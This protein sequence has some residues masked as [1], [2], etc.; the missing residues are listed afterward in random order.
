MSNGQT[1]IKNRVSV[2]R[3][4]II[5]LS[6]SAVVAFGILI[7]LNLST[8]NR[9][10]LGAK[11]WA[12]SNMNSLLS[13][14]LAGAVR[15]KKETPVIDSLEAFKQKDIDKVFLNA[16]V[17]LTDN[18]PW[19][20]FE[21]N[22]SSA[23]IWPQ[24]FIQQALENEGN[25]STSIGNIFTTSSPILNAKNERIGTLITSWNHQPIIQQITQDSI[26]AALVSL[27]LMTMMVAFIILFNRKLVIR[28]LR[29]ITIT[30]SELAEGNTALEVPEL[31][32]RDEIG[33]IASALEVLKNNAIIAEKLKQQKMDADTENQRQK[34]ILE[35]AEKDKRESEAR[36]QKKKL[37][38]AE[39]SAAHSK[40]LKA[41]ISTL[42]KA[43][44]AASNGNLEYP[45][46]CTQEEDD[47][48]SI[49]VALDGLFKQLRTSFHDIEKSATGVSQAATELS[50]IGKSITT[51][52]T[53][54]FELTESASARASNVSQSVQT[55]AT[56]T[57]E[58]TSTIKE[59]SVNASNAVRTVIEAVGLVES[60][61]SNINRLSDSSADI[62]SVIKDITS[63]AEQTNLLAL[64][65]T[66]EA[67]RAGDAGKGFA[68]VANEVK[69]LAKDTA[70]A[71]EEIE[72]RIE[73]IQTDTKTAVAAINQINDVVANI[74]NSQSSIAAAVE[75][76]KATSN[77]LH[78]TIASASSDNTAINSVF[79]D[80]SEQSRETKNTAISVNNAA[81]ELTSHARVLS[82]LLEHWRVPS[83]TSQ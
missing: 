59:I 66:I 15:W 55:A 20:E 73:S 71:T 54:N 19:V 68:V 49:A 74:S 62:G 23:P 2:S 33:A 25:V 11:S 30:L 27:G 8:S 37:R 31:G 79:H 14:Q 6:V 34:Q 42:L 17:F 44:D 29:Q 64:N 47:L 24:D 3:T 1:S 12:H 18:E 69:E 76:Q 22:A 36:Q 26:T 57:E 52:S 40:A 51:S 4:L 56:A 78:R 32:R 35:A 67:A 21:G 81:E 75:Q 43:V 77:E 82:T 80:V 5:T 53:K 61:G 28:P 65:A 10:M 41:R 70:R 50:D 48:A 46:D 7:A 16:H 83:S 63:I 38:E 58:M 39:E 60:T 9:N 13:G 45:I 72:N